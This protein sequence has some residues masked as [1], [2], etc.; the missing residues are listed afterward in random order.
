M[1]VVHRSDGAASF[2]HLRRIGSADKLSGYGNECRGREQHLNAVETKAGSGSR[3]NE[4]MLVPSV[5]VQRWRGGAGRVALDHRSARAHE[6]AA[7]DV[8]RSVLQAWP[9]AP[10]P[11][12]RA[13]DAQFARSAG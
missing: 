12:V 10:M 8:Q 3:A 6:Y 7:S 11:A 5:L 9:L 1:G 4:T 13:P 2:N